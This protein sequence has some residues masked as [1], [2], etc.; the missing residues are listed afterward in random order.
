MDMSSVQ[1]ISSQADLGAKTKGLILVKGIGGLGNRMLA[2]LTASL[3]A[4]A[5]GR[6]LMVDWR[7]AIY[8]GRGGTAPNL[9]GD[10]FISPIVDQLPERIEAQ[11]VVPA[12]WQG[13][14]DETLAVVGRSHDPKFYKHFGSFRHLAV[15]LRRIDYAQGVLPVFWS[16]REVLR[17][18]RP[19][20]T[21]MDERFT[22]MS[23]W[24]ILREAASRYL[25][26]CE[27]IRTT[28]DHYI[29]QHFTHR[30][31][32]LHIRA[33]DALA[34][35][36]KLIR[37]AKRLVRQQGCDGV[38]CAT[39]SAEMEERMRRTL[40]NVLILPKQMPKEVIPLHYDPACKDRVE[41]ATQALMD[42]LLL[43]RCQSLSYSGR[44]SFGYMASILAPIGQ[45]SVDVDR[46]HPIIMAKRFVQSWIY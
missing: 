13:R 17:P 21:R 20:L 8:T 30:M 37:T 10:L 22:G 24:E 16:W 34:P 19:H 12:L 9:F 14:L 33:T 11:S 29:A 4:A 31:L 42:I 25:Q 27:R 46:Y 32:G 18:L 15:D 35:V 38:F 7:D 5:A 6:R 41:R 40:P 2:F 26:P 3:F 23:D 1:A 28:V 45:V 44:S 36:G 39:D 43:S